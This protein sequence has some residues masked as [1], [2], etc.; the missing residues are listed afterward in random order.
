MSDDYYPQWKSWLWRFVRT[1]LSG[2]ASTVIALNVVLKPDFS[3]FRV[4]STTIISAFL[5][6][7]ISSLMLAFR[8]LR[9]SDDKNVGVINKLPL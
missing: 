2:G 3:D 7:A 5:A 9:G 1:A 6:G 8:D 4:Y